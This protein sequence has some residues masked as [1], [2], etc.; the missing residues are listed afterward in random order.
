MFAVMALVVLS[1]PAGAASW[2][3]DLY[4]S[5]L[6]T[7]GGS[8]VEPAVA[9]DAWETVV[10]ELG[11]AVANKPVAPAETLGINGFDVGIGSSITFIHSRDTSDVEPSAWTRMDENGEPSDVLWVPWVQVR[12]GLP[13]SLEMGANLGYVAFSRQ[14]IFG[15]YGRWGIMEGYW[16]IPDLS[17]QVGYS[18]YV[19]NRELE[20][21]TLDTTATVGYTLP[22]GTIVGIN[23][24]QF[25]P[26]LGG[27]LLRIHA[28]PRLSQEEQA[29]I[30]ISQVSGFNGSDYYNQA[31]RRF[32]LNGGFRIVNGDFQLRISASYAPGVVATVNAGMGFTY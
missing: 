26:F 16:P 25:S 10:Q 19:G 14:T 1:A 23:Q 24:A 6:D 30:G 11:V 28:A 15:G 20:L 22:F 8:P 27:G 2:P 17:L 18:G 9:A 3:D 7:Y 21:G 13:L 4:P 29:D 5:N 32:V 12:K 31:F